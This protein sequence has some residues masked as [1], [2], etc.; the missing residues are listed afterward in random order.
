MEHNDY[1]TRV[2]LKQRHDELMAA[3]RKDAMLR[4]AGVHRR[5]LRAALGMA[6][7]R[8]GAWLLREHYVLRTP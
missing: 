3:A 6:L 5:P 2:L 7:I 4:A 1:A 8:V